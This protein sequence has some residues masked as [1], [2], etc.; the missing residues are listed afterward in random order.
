M[1]ANISQY[2]V[3]INEIRQGS[4][5]FVFRMADDFFNHFQNPE[6]LSGDFEADIYMDKKSDLIVCDC[7]ITGTVNTIC[8]RCLDRFELPLKYEGF[9]YIKFGNEEAVEADVDVIYLHNKETEFNLARFLY[10]SICL[11]A[12]FKKVHSDDENGVSTCNR[13][14]LKKLE[15]YS[16]HEH[17][18]E[19]DMRWNK[20]K[21]LIKNKN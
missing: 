17:N 2:T 16:P 7:R 14:M 1:P 3:K 5:H 13:D 9:L 6:F 15:K 4:N 18:R 19:T 10:E 11:S 8:D 12:P 21:N 20:L